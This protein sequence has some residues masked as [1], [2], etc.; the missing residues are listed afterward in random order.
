MIASALY[1]DMTC[2]FEVTQTVDSSA[3]EMLS[4]GADIMSHLL[5]LPV[6]LKKW[7][8]AYVSAVSHRRLS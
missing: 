6:E 3:Y 4:T 2:T 8:V 1:E 5:G 7:I